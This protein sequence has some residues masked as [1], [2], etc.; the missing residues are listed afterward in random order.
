MR[1]RSRTGLGSARRRRVTG[2]AAVLTTAATL[3]PWSAADAA[4]TPETDRLCSHDEV[5]CSVQAPAR[6]LAGAGHEVGVTGRPDTSITLRAY[7]LTTATN[8]AVR[9][10]PVGPDLVVTTDENGWGS[11][12]LVLPASRQT[13]GGPLLL[14]PVESEGE[15][16][17]E[18]LGAW[19][20]LLEVTPEVVGDGHAERKP[21]G[22]PLTLHLDHVAPGTELAVQRRE[23]ADWLSVPAADGASAPESG[24]VCGATRCTLTYVVPRGLAGSQTFRLLDT[25]RGLP[26]ATWK[27]RPDPTGTPLPV[28]DPDT[29]EPLSH[30]VVGSQVAATGSGGS[31]VS[32]PR[33]RNLDVPVLHSASG[34]SATSA[35]HVPGTVTL[36]AGGVG[37]LA[38]LAALV[39]LPVR[40][41]R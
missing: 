34:A 21:V 13:H 16:L 30:A 26:V 29:F 9:W 32:R 36:V 15:P 41:R 40:R 11:D 18:V 37:A 27:V 8:G 7:L 38:L 5:R 39:G 19:S 3:L 24:T 6:W 25:R 23:G 17:G 1:A 2:L 10:Q 31:S 28:P 35:A 33:G 14:A 12:D 4:S 20:E 22:V